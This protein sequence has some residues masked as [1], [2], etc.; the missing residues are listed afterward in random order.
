MEDAT[1]VIVYRNRTEKAFDELLYEY[2]EVV[3]SIVGGGIAI[4]FVAHLWQKHFWK[5]RR[6]YRERFRR[7]N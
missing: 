1:Q 2:P 3:L 7:N 6:W 4:A 5:V